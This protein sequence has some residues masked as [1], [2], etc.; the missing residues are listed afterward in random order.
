MGATSG[1]DALCNAAIQ[2][3]AD[4]V[5]LSGL[6]DEHA[7]M[8][9]ALSELQRRKDVQD[10]PMV[11]VGTFNGPSVPAGLKAVFPPEQVSGALIEWIGK[12]AKSEK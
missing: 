11:A 4:M 9:S 5:V 2:E 12:E 3:D 7:E 6:S 8:L 10:I 1:A